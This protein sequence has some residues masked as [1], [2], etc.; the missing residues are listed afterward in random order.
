MSCGPGLDSIQDMMRI[1]A[2]SRYILLILNCL[3][4]G[5]VTRLWSGGMRNAH[6]CLL[7]VYESRRLGE[8]VEATKQGD[9]S[10]DER[11]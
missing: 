3:L 11:I 2:M 5:V 4:V 10:V 9:G 8:R 1:I 7:S 6:W